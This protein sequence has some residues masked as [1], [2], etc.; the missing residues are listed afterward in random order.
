MVE[1]KK[2]K[3]IKENKKKNRK[4]KKKIKRATLLGLK[5]KIDKE[6]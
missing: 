1:T 6:K 2:K 3:Q 4:R 5:R